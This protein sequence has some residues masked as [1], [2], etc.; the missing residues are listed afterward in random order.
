MGPFNF[1]KAPPTTSYVQPNT[2]LKK[3][4]MLSQ[5]FK[6]VPKVFDVLGFTPL[7]IPVFSAVISLDFIFLDD[8]SPCMLDDI[9]SLS[10]VFLAFSFASGQD[11][12]SS[13]SCI[14]GITRSGS[15]LALVEVRDDLLCGLSGE[16]L[17]CC[18]CL[19]LSTRVGLAEFDTAEAGVNSPSESLSSPSLSTT[20]ESPS[21]GFARG[22]ACDLCCL[23]MLI[24]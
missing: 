23:G 1:T 14:E 12:S 3:F 15:T 7:L 17:G 16:F 11:P 6:E 19:S 2:G 4:P 22:R 18:D 8:F 9:R 20:Q 10:A 24:L 13:F 5:V 21:C